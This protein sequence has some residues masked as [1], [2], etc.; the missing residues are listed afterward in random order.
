MRNYG[1]VKVGSAIPS[2][3]VADVDYN[4]SQIKTIISRAVAEGVEVVCFPELCLT[5]Y[6]CQDLFRSTLLL[7]KAEA[8]IDELTDYCAALPI[9]VIVGAP[10]RQMN[11]LYNAAVVIAAGAHYTVNKTYIPNYNEFYEQRWFAPED[12]STPPVVF[13][14]LSGVKFSVEICEDLWA[15]IPP[16]S[17]A[18][19][20]GA[21]IIF[22]L[23]ATDEFVG[24]HQYLLSLLAQQSARCMAGYVYSSAGF[25]E[26]TQDVV[27]AGNALIYENGIALAQSTRFA[28][29]EQLITAQI[30]V[31]RLRT[32]RQSNTTFGHTQEAFYDDSLVIPL[33]VAAPTTFTLERSY[34]P[35]PFVPAPAARTDACEEIVNIQVLG[36]ARRLQHTHCRDVV[37]GISGGLDSTLAL[38]VCVATFDKLGLDRKGIHGIT[39]PGL[40][41]SA[42]THSNALALMSALHISQQEIPIAAAVEQHFKDIAHDSAVHDVTFENAQA[43]YRTLVLMDLANKVGG[44]VVG[45]GDLSELAL[46]WCTYNGDHMSMYA[47]NIGVPKTMVQHLVR[48]IAQQCPAATADILLDIV[49]TPISPELTPTDEQGNIHQKTEDIIGPYELHDFFLYHF[50]RYGTAPQK[51]LLLAANAFDGS[52][53][54]A[55]SAETIK[56]TLRRFLQRFF[57]Q[58]FKRSCLPDG[59]KV[60]SVAL[61]PRGDW[62]MPS[63]ADVKAFLDD[64][65]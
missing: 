12:P 18:A 26:S 7:D 30:D 61:S 37:I 54:T 1:F 21:D 41:T 19:V 57:A 2:V 16:S 17:Y 44:L 59:P 27:Y 3:R 14:L 33:E 11:R 53:G 65:E 20:V 63:D 15:P 28:L 51:L 39:M 10:L 38:L 22:N 49:D 24:K 64:C 25:G 5:G 42:R 56:T 46:G 47:V 13:E 9:V 32:A 23:S 8:A 31:E 40:G 48:Y 60:G 45:T 58:Q 6:S 55:Y 36:L 4:V 62:R 29:N 34:S 52:H 43:R 50:L 35:H